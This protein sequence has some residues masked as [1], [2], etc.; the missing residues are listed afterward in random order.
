[1]NLTGARPVLAL[2]GSLAGTDGR[3]V[4]IATVGVWRLSVAPIP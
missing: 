4:S 1:M 3:V 2:A